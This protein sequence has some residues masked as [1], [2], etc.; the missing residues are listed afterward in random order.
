MPLSTYL[1][2]LSALE[3]LVDTARE[4]SIGAAARLQ[5]I[6]QQAASE[7]LRAVEAQ[8]GSTLLTRTPRGSKLTATGTV[9]VEWATRLLE[10]AHQVDNA[11][12]ALR[13]DRDGQLRISASMTIAEHLLPRWLVLLRQHQLDSGQPVTVVNLTATNTENAIEAVRLGTSTLGF[14][15]GSTTPL[16]IRSRAVGTDELLL[17]AHPS[18]RWA[19]RRTP[20]GATE[21]ALTSLTMR[22][23]GSGTR[24]VLEDALALSGYHAAEAEV[25]LSTSTAVRESVRAGSAPTVIS[26][27][28]VE[29]DIASGRLVRLELIG[30]DLRRT[31]RAIWIGDPTPPAGPVREMLAVAKRSAAHT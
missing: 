2:D 8:V 15:E 17:V 5:G 11:I 12:A 13:Q 25:E 31:L 9:V 28:A 19:R 4:G 6:S 26:S 24:Q 14:I 21:L 10:N 1:P 30:L 23:R 3:L 7:R 18:H 27:H 22:E 16:Q 29:A 20:I